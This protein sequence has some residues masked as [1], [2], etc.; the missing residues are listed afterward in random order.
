MSYSLGV[1]L[2]TTYSAAAV[3][4]DG[5]VEVCSLGVTSATLPSVVLLRADETVL[6]GEAA[7]RRGVVEP[8]RVGR[9]FK[10]RLGDPTPLILGGT[11]YGAE[12]LTGHLLKAIVAMVSE[13]EGEA[14]A[15]VVLT[16]PVNYGPY[17]LDMVREAARLAGI[18]SDRLRL[19][20]EPVAAAISYATR[21]RVDVNSTF[22]VYDFGGG[23]FDAAVLR[24]TDQGFTVVGQPEGMERF[25]GI[26]IDAAMLAFVDQQLD[27][28]L[29][30]LEDSSPE[31]LEDTSALRDACRQAKETL[32][33]DTDATIRVQ[34]ANLR[35]SVGISRNDLERMIRPRIQ[36]TIESLRRAVQSANVTMEQIST[37][38]LVGGSSR[39]PL[40]ADLVARETRRPVSTD[41]HPKLAIASGA[42]LFAGGAPEARRSVE[43][44]PPMGAPLS[45]GNSSTTA[46]RS[47]G[48]SLPPPPSAAAAGDRL[49]VASA[50]LPGQ[51]PGDH[52]TPLPPWGGDDAGGGSG[53]GGGSGR[54]FGVGQALEP[55]RKRRGRAPV[56]IAGLVAAAIIATVIII[57]TRSKTETANTDTPTNTTLAAG[58]AAT[59]STTAKNSPGTT[60]TT[61]N[62]ASVVSPVA[63][64]AAVP[65][66]TT[67][68]TVPTAAGGTASPAD[69]APVVA[70]N[71]PPIDAGSGSPAIDAALLDPTFMQGGP[72]A[73][74]DVTFQLSED[75]CGDRRPLDGLVARKQQA[76]S[77]PAEGSAGQ[78]EFV[79]QE[80]DVFATTAQAT[81]V[82][83][84]AITAT[85]DCKTTVSTD[86]RNLAVQYIMLPPNSGLTGCD[87]SFAFEEIESN[88][89]VTLNFDYVVMRCGNNISWLR[90]SVG[91]TR[92]VRDARLAAL[93]AIFITSSFGVQSMP[94]LP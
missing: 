37:I 67:S 39:I 28:A 55:A 75:T 33:L 94:V 62:S 48:L 1:D 70:T 41:A 81:A 14:P 68:G 93:G 77:S 27:G 8:G 53:T 5:R 73:K 91:G 17:K 69:T 50:P 15:I 30:A 2:G 79:N 57:A 22:A 72:W 54:G 7:E 29:G 87:Q 19:L 66:V 6:V 89:I 82:V 80:I 4:R 85:A 18:R 35:R 60:A 56:L 52:H 11:P 49:G 51:R 31:V 38:L 74:S 58:A 34:L 21:Q 59:A 76:F 90:Y 61:V 10:R 78:T 86:G 47:P 92:I 43:P 63:T 64:T 42:A 23:T 24:R 26:D 20:P 25:G 65:L 16:H 12:A 32:S 36:E 9:E 3:C 40:V 71:P 83:D 45:M 46:R 13:R 88:A 84:A 44:P